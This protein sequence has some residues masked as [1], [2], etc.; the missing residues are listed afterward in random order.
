[1][2]LCL[3]NCETYSRN[4]RDACTCISHILSCWWPLPRS[5]LFFPPIISLVVCH[6][7]LPVSLFFHF[8]YFWST[9]WCCSVSISFHVQALQTSIDVTG[10]YLKT[11]TR[12]CGIASG[13]NKPSLCRL[14]F[15][16]RTALHPGYV[17]RKWYDF[18]AHTGRDFISDFSFSVVSKTSL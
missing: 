17:H 3:K 12:F 5:T 18:Y 2:N 14:F 13:S 4:I 6:N 7:I 11:V 8:L 9:F 16:A 15:T 10:Q 1:M